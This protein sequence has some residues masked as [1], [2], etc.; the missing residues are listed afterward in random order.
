MKAPSTCCRKVFTAYYPLHLNDHLLPA[1]H[2]FRSIVSAPI[3]EMARGSDLF[4]ELDIDAA[5]GPV[6]SYI[7]REIT[8]AVL[9]A[10][11]IG[12]FGD[13]WVNVCDLVQKVSFPT[14]FLSYSL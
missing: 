11:F 9:V 4:V 10:K 7:G 2:G 12:D 6:P 5:P 3:T 8:N 1:V 13:N 14:R